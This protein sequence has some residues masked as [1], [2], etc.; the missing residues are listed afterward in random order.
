VELCHLR[1]PEVAASVT[2]A[3][4]AK[5]DRYGPS[6]VGTVVSAQAVASTLRLVPR[7]RQPTSCW[8]NWEQR[9]PLPFPSVV[10]RDTVDS[11]VT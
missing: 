5:Y 8:E 3:Y 1:E 7:V 9:E 6:I 11:G 10:E 2:A 4:H